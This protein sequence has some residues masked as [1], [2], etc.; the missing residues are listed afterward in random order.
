MIPDQR[1][2][3]RLMLNTRQPRIFDVP[4]ESLDFADH[5]VWYIR[6]RDEEDKI[7][8]QLSYEFHD[9]SSYC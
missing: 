7:Q 9:D 2:P 8:G 3:F 6:G 5:I 1:N 4:Q